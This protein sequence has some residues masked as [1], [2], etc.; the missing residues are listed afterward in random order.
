MSTGR[1]S[2]QEPNPGIIF[3]T[4]NAYQRSAALKT[5]IELDVFTKIAQGNRSSDAIAKA[6]SASARGVRILCD[7]LVV[8]GFLSKDGGQYSLTGESGMFLDRNSPAYF[9]SV[10]SFLLDPRLISPFLNLSDVVRAG[11]TTLPDEGTVSRDNPIWVDF[12]KQMTPMIFPSAVEIA[13]LVAGD[14]DLRVLDIAAGHGLFGI[15]IAQQNSKARVTALDWPNV[16][17]V[18]TENAEKFGVASRHRT[19]AGDAFEADY[20]GPYDLIL[21]TNFFHH[22]DPPTCETLMRKI[23]VALAP[24][25]RCVTLDFVPNDD[26]VSPPM[27]AGFA[28][29]MLGTTAAG[30][31]Y[32]FTDYQTMFSHAGFASSELHL[33]MKSPETVIVSRKA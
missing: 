14:G 30:D 4:L 28:M 10:A 7:Y 12:A 31:V 33:L 13:G 5:A 1:T 21:V 20:E 24:G 8:S 29:M 11:R 16:L 3:D 23:L 19:L 32:T 17:A 15:M 6:V 2:V 27:A 22:F 26:R 18:A 25:G 9:G